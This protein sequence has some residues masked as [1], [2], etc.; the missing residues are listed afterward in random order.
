MAWLAAS[1]T[2][3]SRSHDRAASSARHFALELET[4]P[5]RSARRTAWGPAENFVFRGS[6]YPALRRGHGL[7]RF[8][9]G[10]QPCKPRRRPC[11]ASARAVFS[12][13]G[14]SPKQPGA[15][16]VGSLFEQQNIRR[17][18]RAGHFATAS[19]T[20]ASSDW[21][22]EVTHPWRGHGADHILRTRFS[23]VLSELAGSGGKVALIGFLA[24]TEGEIEFDPSHDED[25]VMIGIGVGS[26][27]AMFR[28][29][30][31]GHQIDGLDH[32]RRALLFDKAAD[33]Y[34]LPGG[35]LH[36][37][38]RDNGLSR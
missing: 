8:D 26:C 22:K 32:G 11:C 10:G 28:R 20:N 18:L 29:H 19:I 14:L 17:T 5:D 27:S 4:P 3:I 15:R 30:E 36:R 2:W 35:W 13:A 12:M 31:S 9:G 25:S 24:G 1:Q 16:V 6:R 7:E 34:P 21:Q 33:A 38:G 23:P 37:Q